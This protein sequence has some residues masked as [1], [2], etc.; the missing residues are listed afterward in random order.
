MRMLMQCLP[1]TLISLR[2]SLIKNGKIFLLKPFQKRKVEMLIYPVQKKLQV[3]PAERTMP[4]SDVCGNKLDSILKQTVPKAELSL[5][6]KAQQ[7]M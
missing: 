1:R 2:V 7:I 5:Y 3:V 6:H 4:K